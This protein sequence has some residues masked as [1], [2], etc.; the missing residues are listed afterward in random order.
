MTFETIWL[1][2]TLIWYVATTFLLYQ[3]VRSARKEKNILLM[4]WM[5]FLL[6]CQLGSLVGVVYLYGAP[7]SC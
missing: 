6:F 1:I 4:I 5:I 7:T 2:C 3:N